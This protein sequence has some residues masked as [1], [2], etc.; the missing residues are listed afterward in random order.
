MYRAKVKI[1]AKSIHPNV[2]IQPRFLTG[3]YMSP[4]KTK[5]KIEDRKEDL[6]KQILESYSHSN[7]ECTDMNVEIIEFKKLPMDFCAKGKE[8]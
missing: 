8:K 4:L 2:R 1:T 7:K 5:M 6:R 3:V